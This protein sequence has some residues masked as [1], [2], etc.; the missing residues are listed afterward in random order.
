MSAT[1]TPHSTE[2]SA[3]PNRAAR[4]LAIGGGKGGAG[5]TV[6]TS[7]LCVQLAA[8]GRR[9][10][11]L[12]ADLGGA[13][14]HTVLGVPPPLVTLTD[15]VKKR[16]LL[17]DIAINTPFPNLRLIAGALHD[18]NAANPAHQQKMRLL[19]HLSTLECDDLVIDLGAGTGYNIVDFFLT[20]DVPIVVVQPE[21]TSVENAYRFL[22][23]A[24]VRRLR[25]VQ[26]V[27]K[28]KGLLDSILLEGKR[29]IHTPADLVRAIGD[30]DPE[31]GQQVTDLMRSFVPHLVVNQVQH[32]PGSTDGLVARDMASAC[33]RFFGIDLK[34]LGQLPADDAVKRSVRSRV[35]FCV[36]SPD[37]EVTK[38]LS[39]ITQ[40]LLVEDFAKGQDA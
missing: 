30:Q 10:I 25:A 5:K 12:D 36:D 15:F 35:P 19:R 27:F 2:T 6:F 7:N 38:A 37:A 33:R 34:E 28:I 20:A 32:T 17:E 16:S 11:L 13:N 40:K 21:P 8:S 18:V 26:R 24:Y 29:N 23:A 39:G 4:I 3:K 31:M 22:K 1:P 14:A 9:V